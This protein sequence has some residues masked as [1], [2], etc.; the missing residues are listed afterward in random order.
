MSCDH[1]SINQAAVN[2]IR[3]KSNLLEN[4]MLSLMEGTLNNVSLFL[5][6]VLYEHL[7]QINF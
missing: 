6:L 1:A 3:I 7:K 4:V 2:I 5:I